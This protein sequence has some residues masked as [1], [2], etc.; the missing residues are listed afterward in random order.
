MIFKWGEVFGLD[1]DKLKVS[2]YPEEGLMCPQHIEIIQVFCEPLESVGSS[3]LIC[4]LRDNYFFNLKLHFEL[5]GIISSFFIPCYS[6]RIEDSVILEIKCF[7]K[8]L[9]CSFY[10]SLKNVKT[11]LPDE[12]LICVNWNRNSDTTSSNIKVNSII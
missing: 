5:Q 8:S 3:K 12:E 4:F 9:N 2:I 10:F 1:K 7:V 11:W 6:E